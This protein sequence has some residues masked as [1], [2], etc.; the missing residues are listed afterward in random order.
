MTSLPGAATKVKLAAIGLQKIREK[1]QI[2]R[3]HAPALREFFLLQRDLVL[4]QFKDLESQFTVQSSVKTSKATPI[5]N[6][7]LDKAWD[8]LWS[9]IEKETTGG[10]QDIII[11]IERDAMPKGAAQLKT[12]FG[13]EKGTGKFW[14]LANPRAVKWFMN[15]GGSVDYIKGIQK[16]TS[17]SLK[18]VI[19]QGLDEGWSYND[20]AK[21]IRKFYAGMSRERSTTIAVHE[22]AQAYEAG[23]RAFADGLVD[24]GIEVEKR[25]ENSGD[26]K[27]SDG[28]LENTAAGWIPINESFPSGD[29]QAPRFPG[30]RCWIAY[31]QKKGGD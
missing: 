4:Q 14:D 18:G 10:L 7:V 17:E 1:N 13:L 28:C 9:G 16:T 31:R 20:T 5:P 11:G 26:D 12:L 23:N 27:V 19:T 15:H 21:E 22:S 25:W 3:K 30:C 8:Q 6:V 29:Q 24:D 2:A